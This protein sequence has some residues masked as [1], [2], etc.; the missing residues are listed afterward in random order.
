MLP[1]AVGQNFGLLLRRLTC[2]F[3]SGNFD[4]FSILGCIFCS[5]FRFYFLGCIFLEEIEKSN[6]ISIQMEPPNS[7]KGRPIIAGPK[8]PSQ[9]LSSILEK[10]L[11]PLVPKLRSYIKDDWD[12]FKKLP[13]NLDPNFAFL[14]CDIASLYTNIPDELGLRALLYYIAK[15][16]NLIPVRFR[17]QFIL[18]AAKFLI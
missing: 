16:R 18:E 17:E 10:I 13:R 6:E 3:P 11:T 14:R 12:F 1:F 4:K 7:L 2:A 8:S 15:Y 9:R 5:I